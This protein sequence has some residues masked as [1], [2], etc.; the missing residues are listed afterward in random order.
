MKK[1]KLLFACNNLHI[2]GIQRSLL[3]LL[4]EISDKYDITLFLF[5][6][7]GE[8]ELPKNVRI[9]GGN[10]FTRIMGMSQSEAA[11]EGM[12]CRLWRSLWVVITRIFGCKIPFAALCCF[13][14]LSGE[15]HNVL[16]E[17]ITPHGIM[18][19]LV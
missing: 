8:Y 17:E 12:K 9:I 10:R 3:N 15:Y 1:Q 13:Q 7:G 18:G 19:K 2:G 4:D 11:E 5:Y 6:P 16:P 14:K